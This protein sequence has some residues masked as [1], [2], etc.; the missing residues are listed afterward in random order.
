MAE[1]NG[2]KVI[3]MTP[4]EISERL[5]EAH[6]RWREHGVGSFDR[7]FLASSGF[8]DLVAVAANNKAYFDQIAWKHP[9]VRYDWVDRHRRRQG[10]TARGHSR[11]RSY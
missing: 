8:T 9:A 2:S 11:T 7:A 10:Y 4:V 6:A 5:G 3:S 1:E